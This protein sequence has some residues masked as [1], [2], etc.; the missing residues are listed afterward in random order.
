MYGWEAGGL[1]SGWHDTVQKNRD[2]D[3]TE[4]DTINKPCILS[5]WNSAA[6]RIGITYNVFDYTIR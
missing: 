4:S 3:R 5:Q 6:Q 1:W 2:Y